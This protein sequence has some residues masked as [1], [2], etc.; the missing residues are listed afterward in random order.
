M[1]SALRGGRW[2]GVIE[3]IRKDGQRITARAVIAPRRSPDGTLMGFLLISAVTVAWER[4]SSGEGPC[5][6]RHSAVLAVSSPVSW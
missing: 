3:C 5:L 2:E 4:S 6:M 1:D